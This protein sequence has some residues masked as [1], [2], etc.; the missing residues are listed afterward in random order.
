MHTEMQ[1]IV[2]YYH[3]VTMTMLVGRRGDM[4]KTKFLMVHIYRSTNGFLPKTF[5]LL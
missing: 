2:Q 5:G 4:E 1:V 3:K